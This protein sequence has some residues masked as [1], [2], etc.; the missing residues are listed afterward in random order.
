MFFERQNSIHDFLFQAFFFCCCCRCKFK[1]SL[2]RE[3][4]KKNTKKQQSY[5]KK[6][7]HKSL[8]YRTSVTD[9]SDCNHSRPKIDSWNSFSILET[10]IFLAEHKVHPFFFRNI[11]LKKQLPNQLTLP[12]LPCVVQMFQDWCMFWLRIL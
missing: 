12:N 10:W 9:C 5:T 2:F 3:K 11:K 7:P 8:L 4:L 1:P 6:G